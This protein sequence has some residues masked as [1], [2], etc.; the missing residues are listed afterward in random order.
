MI[1]RDSKLLAMDKEVDLQRIVNEPTQGVSIRWRLFTKNAPEG[2]ILE[3][4]GVVVEIAERE[5]FLPHESLVLLT[6]LNPNHEYSLE[7]LAELMGYD[8]SHK[9]LWSPLFPAIAYLGPLSGFAFLD[10]KKASEED[11]TLIYSLNSRTSLRGAIMKGIVYREVEDKEYEDRQVST[12][13][14]N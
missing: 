12:E 13:T 10:A 2:S 8:P 1:P 9:A 6:K 7:Q 3:Y 14:V 4:L 11:T 5:Y